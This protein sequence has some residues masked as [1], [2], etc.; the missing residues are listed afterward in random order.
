M[1]GILTLKGL[2]IY[3]PDL[4]KDNLYK[5]IPNEMQ[6]GYSYEEF[7][8]LILHNVGGMEVLYPEPECFGDAVNAWAR[9]LSPVW[10]AIRTRKLEAMGITGGQEVRNRKFG[11]ERTDTINGTT[12]SKTSGSDETDMDVSAFN[13]DGYVPKDRQ[14][15]KYG[16]N[17]TNTE[18]T[19][20]TTKGS[21]TEE[22]TVT[23]G[24][25][26]AIEIEI[27]K[28]KIILNMNVMEM[29]VTMFKEQFFL[30]VY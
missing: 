12:G 25:K 9:V 30:S 5:W 13:I 19:T 26:D 29:I 21:N 8:V 6:E 18:N 28:M 20:N 24:T 27:E 1:S 7:E 11:T 10:E 2:L 15:V 23:R 4:L 16:G 14:T 22:E 17:V 3:S